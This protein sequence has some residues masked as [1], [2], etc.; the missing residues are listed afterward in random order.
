MITE[1]AGQGR[2]GY[3]ERTA[4][5]FRMANLLKKYADMYKIAILVTNQVIA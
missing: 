4:Q 2:D 3:A 1:I 5:L